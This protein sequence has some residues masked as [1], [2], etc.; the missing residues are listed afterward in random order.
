MKHYRILRKQYNPS[1]APFFV[2]QVKKKFLWWNYWSSLDCGK[3]LYN[4]DEAEKY[5]KHIMKQNDYFCD[6]VKEWNV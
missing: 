4:L 1:K 6:I 3:L 2:C 5:I